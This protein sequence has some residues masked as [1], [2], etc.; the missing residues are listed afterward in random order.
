[1]N[2]LSSRPVRV[3]MV[4]LLQFVFIGAAVSGQLSAR[5]AGREYL[6]RVEP[7]DPID[8]FRGAYVALNYQDLDLRREVPGE[9]GEAFV[10]LV[11]SGDFWRA[12]AVTRR[13]PSAGPYL[14]CTDSHGQL[15][16]GIESYFLPQGKAKALE[17][18]LR[19]GVVVARV[20]VDGRGHAALVGVQPR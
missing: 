5:L 4:V 2:A 9:A 17:D 10:S 16:C 1:M 7:L 20:N 8:P 12:G 15:S 18:A 19:R 11:A 14:A 6:L 13:R 3:A